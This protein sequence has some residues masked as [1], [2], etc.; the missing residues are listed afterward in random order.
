M[1]G[2]LRFSDLCTTSAIASATAMTLESEVAMWS[3]A[4]RR[5]NSLIPQGAPSP[6]EIEM[7]EAE[8][9]SLMLLPSREGLSAFAPFDQPPTL[10]GM[11]IRIISG[12][13]ADSIRIS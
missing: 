3:E 2:K 9:V 7:T 1:G 6:D 8:Y 11:R 5:L 10:L 4:W 12:R 13:D